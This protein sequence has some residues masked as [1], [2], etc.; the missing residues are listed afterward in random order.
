MYTDDHG[1]YSIELNWTCLAPSQRVLN[2]IVMRACRFNAVPVGLESS[3]IEIIR[4][5]DC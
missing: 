4:G 2:G 3:L 1:A 5:D